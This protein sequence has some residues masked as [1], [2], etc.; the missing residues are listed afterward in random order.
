MKRLLMVFVVACLC[1]PH[2]YAT[3]YHFD[4]VSNENEAN[5]T[6]GEAQLS[7]DVTEA[8]GGANFTFYN[9]GPEG[10]RYHENLF[11]RWGSVSVRFDCGFERRRSV[12]DGNQ[13]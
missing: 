2:L 1:V 13:S 12:C 10:L 7:M 8:A 4:C 11:F 3:L 6:I 9:S 5:I